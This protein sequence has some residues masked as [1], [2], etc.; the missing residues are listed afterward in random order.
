MGK[1]V[2]TELAYY[3][4]GKTKNPHDLRERLEDHLVV[5]LQL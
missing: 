2:T 3:S 4:P 1:T 5:Q